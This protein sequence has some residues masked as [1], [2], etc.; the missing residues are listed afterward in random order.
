[1]I[2]SWEYSILAKI[3]M[4]LTCVFSSERE[5]ERE[6]LILEKYFM[7]FPLVFFCPDE[8]IVSSALVINQ[9][10]VALF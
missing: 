7:F 2:G 9:T 5:R 3:S 1:M 6:M 8:A 10:L 4:T